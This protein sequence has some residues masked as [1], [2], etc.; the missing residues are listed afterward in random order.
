MK[1]ILDESCVMKW[2]N[3]D[4]YKVLKQKIISNVVLVTEEII[5]K[6]GAREIS[7]FYISKS[8]FT[9]QELVD[10][11]N[12]FNLRSI[13][14]GSYII[15]NEYNKSLPIK[16]NEIKQQYV[17][18]NEYKEHPVTGISWEGACFIAK[19]FDA[20]LPYEKEWEIAATSGNS[21]YMYSWG[22]EEPN[23]T[24]SNYE[25]NVG[26]TSKVNSYP[27]NGLGIYDMCGNVDEWCLDGMRIDENTLS[28]YEKVVK[29]GCW[30]KSSDNMICSSKRS[31]WS[32]IG[33]TGIGFRMVFERSIM[34]E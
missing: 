1:S 32:K 30:Y 14:G 10:I 25:E 26:S 34:D 31:R 13:K 3:T 7:P 29:G 33:A 11:L 21:N 20:R 12:L 16:W 28:K 5:D 15:I 9:N 17:V 4:T 22:N 23:S 19:L 27:P 2:K 18:S 24:L 6:Y 8:L